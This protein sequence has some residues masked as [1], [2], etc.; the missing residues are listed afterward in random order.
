MIKPIKP[1][2]RQSLDFGTWVFPGIWGL[3]TWIF[4][5]FVQ[6]PVKP[7]QATSSQIQPNPT[8]NPGGWALGELAH[9]FCNIFSDFLLRKVYECSRTKRKHGKEVPAMRNPPAHRRA[10]RALPGLPAQA[11][12]YRR[13]RHPARNDPV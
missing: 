11:G 2:A 12:H 9:F 5:P 1:E 8:K 13:D 7:G 4:R 6:P 10:G 3:G